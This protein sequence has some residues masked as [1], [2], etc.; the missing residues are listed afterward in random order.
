MKKIIT[1]ILI[2]LFFT[3]TFIITY[4]LLSYNKY[5]ITEFKNSTLLIANKELEDYDKGSLLVVEKNPKL[6]IGDKVFYYDTYSPKVKVKIGTI[7]K[8]EKINEKENTIVLDDEVS[9]SSEYVFGNTKYTEVY[10]TIGSI[11]SIL[12]SKWGYLIIIIFP[13][14]LAF[15][16]EIYEIIK[17]IKRK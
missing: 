15:I 1:N 6:A 2:F 5:N 13:M 16:Y 12:T 8:I 17:E 14:L 3:L 11:F 7:N 10:P 9:I 4:C